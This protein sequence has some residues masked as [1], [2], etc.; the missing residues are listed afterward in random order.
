[1]APKS[2]KSPE[3][4]PTSPSPPRS[5][6]SRPIKSRNSSVASTARRDNH[7]PLNP[8]GLRKSLVP[9]ESSSPED[10][11]SGRNEGSGNGNAEGK[12]PSMPNVKEEGI[13]PTVSEGT[14]TE[15]DPSSQ[16]AE[17]SYWAGNE[18]NT[19]TRLLGHENWDAAS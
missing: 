3:F 12:R 14:E 13:Q 15:I 2:S 19:R 7:A 8:S 6:P 5:P 16:L 10:T 18:P 11:M 1:M 4:L 17:A 9:S